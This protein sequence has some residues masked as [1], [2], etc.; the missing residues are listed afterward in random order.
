MKKEPA[1]PNCGSRLE[2]VP[3]QDG[4]CDWSCPNCGWHQHVP[5]VS[6]RSIRARRAERRKIREIKYAGRPLG[7]QRL[8][9]TA[10]GGFM[11]VWDLPTQNRQ[12]RRKKPHERR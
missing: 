9:P 1:C 11:L 3:D 6:R 12:V 2:Y 8:M 7:K 4:S 10:D 5:P